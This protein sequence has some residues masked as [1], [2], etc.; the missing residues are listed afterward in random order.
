MMHMRIVAPRDR[1]EQVID[2]LCGSDS[3]CNVVVL[4]GAARRPDGD[5]ILCDVAREDASVVIAD[6]KDLGIHKHGSIA[7]EEIDT[8]ISEFARA[9]EKH[10][11]GA[12][13][14]AVIWEEVEQR[15]NE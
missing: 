8:A 6:L 3:V 7:L 4:E 9:A 12:P 15:T 14:D 2:T 1:T 11:R 5:A 10:A 13:S